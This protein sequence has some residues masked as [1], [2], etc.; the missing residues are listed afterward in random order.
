[1]QALELHDFL[2]S[3]WTDVQDGEHQPWGGLG[4]SLQWADKERHVGIRDDDGRLLALAGL[5]TASVAVDGHG[6]FPVV[7][8]GGVIVS[9]S[10]RGEGMA[11]ALLEEVLRISAGVGPKRAMLFCRPEL[12]ALY[13]RFGFKAITPPVVAE[14]STGS[15]EVP[16]RAM[17]LALA[18]GASWPQG[19]VRVLGLPF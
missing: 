2:R 16:L 9:H 15:I 10:R 3:E 17:W 6:E 12:M 5:L 4:E 11:R 14:Q 1:M 13:G 19:G 8:I 18:P 7:G